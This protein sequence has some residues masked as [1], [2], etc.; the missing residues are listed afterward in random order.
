MSEEY[1]AVSGS[2]VYWELTSIRRPP[3]LGRD[4]LQYHLP[5]EEGFSG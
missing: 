3:K 1:S 5:N 4:N 2:Q